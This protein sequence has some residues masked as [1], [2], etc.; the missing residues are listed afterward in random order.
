VSWGERIPDNTQKRPRA[1]QAL[2]VL[3][4]TYFDEIPVPPGVTVTGVELLPDGRHWLLATEQD[5]AAQLVVMRPDGSAYRCLT[6]GLVDAAEKEHV[7]GDGRRIWFANTSGQSSGAVADFQWSVLECSPS[8]YECAAARILPVDFP[9][10]SLTSVPQGA[11]NREATPDDRGEYVTWN[12]VRTLEGTRVTVARLVR[13]QDGYRLVE[14]RVVQPDYRRSGDPE[15]WVDGG[16]FYEGGKFVLGNR[17]LKYQ[18]T[19]TGLNYDTGLLD[20]RTGRYRFMT[21]DLDYNE[22][23]ESSPDGR[24][25]SYSS[26]RGLDRMDVFTQL[27]RP[28]F[29]DMVAFGQLGRVGLFGNRRCMNE[30]WLMD[31]GGQRR[32]GYA[33]QPLLTERNWLARR[34]QWYPDS[35]TMLLTEQLLP[36]VAGGVP[37]GRQYRLRV[38]RLPGKAHAPKPERSLDRV[39]WDAVSVPA[40]DYTGLAARPATVKTLRGRVSGTARLR[41]TGTFASGSWE[42]RYRDYSDDGLNT[43]SG[44]ESITVPSA[45]GTS[46]WAADLRSR[47]R[48]TG[49]TKGRLLID[50]RGSSTG[51]VT[52]EINGR[53]W[54][55][56]PS[57]ADCPGM[58]QPRLKVRVVRHVNGERVVRVLAR[59]AED[60]RARP[61][62]GAQVRVGDRWFV[63]GR[64]GRVHLRAA[65]RGPVRSAQAGGFRTWHGPS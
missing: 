28:P 57:Q 21:R 33:G 58:R 36:N 4:T 29:L 22:T 60:N 17:F 61:V 54:S 8:I 44:T 10:D 7:L 46:V 19:R 63:T 45:V 47:G 40:A 27:V 11:Q 31:F 52:T 51:R 55:G 14:P 24:W 9:I 38:V 5:G 50:P 1:L 6:C 64:R 37:E 62:Q 35:R 2:T 56:V 41:Y 30:A 13:D 42:V 34:R 32:S 53:R 65:T 23:G 3:D 18:T 39:D 26:A 59:P 43:I 49:F 15:D 12:E 25:Y 20:L 16:R 48:R